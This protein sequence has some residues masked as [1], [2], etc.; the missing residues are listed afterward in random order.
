MT[1]KGTCLPVYCFQETVVFS[2]RILEERK[3]EIPISNVFI[4]PK[5]R[6]QLTYRRRSSINGEDSN[7]SLTDSGDETVQ[8][9]GFL[10]DAVSAG[11][12]AMVFEWCERSS[13]RHEYE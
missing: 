2:T 1:T 3:L 6:L 7:A 9:A 5:T 4:G 8:P 12:I 10:K 13:N 11:K